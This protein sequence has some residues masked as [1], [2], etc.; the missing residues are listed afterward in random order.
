MRG[1]GHPR[2]SSLKSLSKKNLAVAIRLL[3]RYEGLECTFLGRECNP[4]RCQFSTQLSDPD[5]FFDPEPVFHIATK[6]LDAEE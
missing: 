5:G 1:F 6:I 4:S 2:T 3:L